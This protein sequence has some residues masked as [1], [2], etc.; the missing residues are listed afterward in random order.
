MISTIL[1]C[2]VS[3]CNR[4]KANRVEA[5]DPISGEE[6]FLYNPREDDWRK[7]F[8]WSDD[9][10]RIVGITAAGRATVLALDLNRE[11]V[12]NIRSA[13]RA[14]GRHPPA[15]DPVQKA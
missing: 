2:L 3:I 6:V 12:I 7:H 8:V 4:R 9:G 10:L 11:R 15:N 14:V 5:L 1:P 13:D